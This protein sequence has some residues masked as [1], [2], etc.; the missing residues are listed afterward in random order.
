MFKR[1]LRSWLSRSSHRSN[2]KRRLMAPG[3]RPS[4]EELEA[5]LAP[6]LFIVNALTDAASGTGGSGTGNSGDLRYCIPQA[7]ALGAT[8]TNTITFG[9][10]GLITLSATLPQL[11]NNVA[12]SAPENS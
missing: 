5:R 6:A 2:Q 3:C 10:S 12:I 9:A 7:N 11:D 4:M 1:M 8:S